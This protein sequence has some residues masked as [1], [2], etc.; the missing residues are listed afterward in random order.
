M[1][2]LRKILFGVKEGGNLSEEEEEEEW[3]T[4]Q[5]KNE[6]ENANLNVPLQL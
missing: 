5:S 4:R 6:G 1:T 2:G 3:G